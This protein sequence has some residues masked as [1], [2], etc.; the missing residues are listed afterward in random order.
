[1]M[2][3]VWMNRISNQGHDLLHVLLGKQ[4]DNITFDEMLQ[5]TAHRQANHINKIY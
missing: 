5:G 3:D 1:M 4:P 2:C